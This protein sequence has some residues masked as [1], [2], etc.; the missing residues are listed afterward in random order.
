MSISN[1]RIYL[2]FYISSTESTPCRI[3]IPAPKVIESSFYVIDIP[4]IAEGLDGAQGGS[5]GTGGG[6]D[7]APRIVNIFYHFSAGAVNQTDN[8]ALE[9]MNVSILRAIELHNSGAVLGVVIALSEAKLRARNPLDCS[10]KPALPEGK[11]AGRYSAERSEAEGSQ[12]F[13]LLPETRAS[14]RE[15]RGAL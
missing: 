9:V 10:P 15:K 1:C 7:F 4:P 2:Y 14:R 6:E 12:S 11:S 5:E 13:G 3:I 8:I